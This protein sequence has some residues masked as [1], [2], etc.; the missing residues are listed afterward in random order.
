MSAISPINFAS[1]YTESIMPRKDE[2]RD[3][4]SLDELIRERRKKQQLE[5][6]DR[7]MTKVENDVKDTFKRSTSE[8]TT[9]P[10]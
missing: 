10:S 2:P 5:E 7:F 1:S 9:K 3:Y 8:N 6:F 4:Y